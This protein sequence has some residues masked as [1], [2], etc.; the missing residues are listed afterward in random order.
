MIPPVSMMIAII[1]TLFSLIMLINS[2]SP[3]FVFI[4]YFIF[5]T[6]PAFFW[7]RLMGWFS[8]GLDSRNLGKA[9]SLFNLSWSFG[10][11]LGPLVGGFVAGYNIMLSFYIDIAVITFIGL[12]L[13]FGMLFIKDLREYPGKQRVVGDGP[14]THAAGMAPNE[15]KNHLLN[16]GKGTFFRF[17]G[18]IGVFS[19]YIVLGLVNNIFPLYVRDYLRFE[20]STAGNLLFTRGLVSAIAFYI[21]GKFSAWHFNKKIMLMVEIC[22][23]IILI[24]MVLSKS[25]FLFYLLFILFG[26]LFSTGYSGGIFH[27]SAGAEDTSRRMALFE[28]FL[29]LGLVAGTV[30]GGYLYQFFSIQTAFI[31]SSMV[32]LLGFLAQCILFNYAKKRGLN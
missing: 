15:K 24:F 22:T 25:I 30:A 20:E 10:S 21:L 3:F 23:V 14:A 4:Y 32:M 31:F 6:A 12:M 18:W 28:S 9:V 11:L 29:T 27:G 13:L 5:A 2:T 17:P 8:Y 16:G 1:L 19:V 26:F 7:P